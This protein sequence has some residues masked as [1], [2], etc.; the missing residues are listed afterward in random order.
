MAN[1]YK[2]VGNAFRLSLQFILEALQNH[3][4]YSLLHYHYRLSLQFILEA[5]QFILEAQA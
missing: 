2:T 3:Y 4:H 1:Y 5:L